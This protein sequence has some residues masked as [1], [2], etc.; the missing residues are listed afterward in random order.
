MDPLR[1]REK[2]AADNLVRRSLLPNALSG[3]DEGNRTPDLLSA[4]QALSQLSYI[5]DVGRFAGEAKKSIEIGPGGS[6]VFGARGSRLA[7]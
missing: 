4:R 1:I 2:K 3:G 5:P 6:Q 7:G